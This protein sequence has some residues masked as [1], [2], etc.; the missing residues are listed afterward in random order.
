[1]AIL[2]VLAFYQIT[3]FQFTLKWDV[4]DAV[5]PWKYLIAD[6]LQNHILPLWNPYQHG[7]YPIHADPQSTAWY[8]ITWFI[9]YFFHYSIYTLMVEWLLHIVIAAWGMYRLGITLKFSPL[10]A[11]IMGLSYS[12]SGFFVGNAQ[13][14]NW[15]IAAAWIPFLIHAYLLMWQNRKWKSAFGFS[16][17]AFML[18]SGAYPAF[19]MI[20]LYLLLILFIYFVIT[21]YRN[22][23]KAALFHFV[24]LNLL[25]FVF[26][27]LNG[28]VVLVSVFQLMPFLQRSGGIALRDALFG[29]FSFT[30]WKSFILPFTTVNHDMSAF[31]TDISMTNGYFGLILFAFLMVAFFQKKNFLMWIFLLFGLLNLLVS[32]GDSLPLRTFFYHYIPF[33]NLFRF[34]ALLRIFS[35]FTFIIIGADALNQYLANPN[36]TLLKWIFGL[37]LAILLTVGLVSSSFQI[38]NLYNSTQWKSLFHYSMESDILQQLYFQL[39]IQII[40][41]GLFFLILR[42]KQDTKWKSAALLLLVFVDLGLATQL[43][44]PYTVYDEHRNPRDTYSEMR[45]LPIGFPLQNDKIL[46]HQTD[47]MTPHFGCIWRNVNTF[48]KQIAPDGYN[49][50]MLK[51]YVFLQDSLPWLL[52]NSNRHTVAFFADNISLVKD[53]KGMNLQDSNMIFVIGNKSIDKLSISPLTTEDQLENTLFIPNEIRFKTQTSVDRLLVLQQN[54]YMGWQIEIDTKKT[55]LINVNQSFMGVIVPSGTHLVK[56]IYKPVWVIIAFVVSIISLMFTVIFVLWSN[57]NSRRL[58]RETRPIGR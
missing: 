6:S 26:T 36:P 54:Y 30:S 17:Y 44:A 7:G 27:L 56:F 31:N 42:L 5:F 11:M 46:L 4:L 14:I 57:V 23:N 19:G 51:D 2:V 25:A 9:G 8:P 10:V 29:P 33:F 15:L 37:L 43:N 55:D 12:M 50:L 1:M 58:P 22:E 18:I 40:A 3:F 49:P 20:L 39:F 41:L 52:R 47:E 38:P 21:I 45:Q 32:L 28:A 16:L 35:I 13:H 53:L 34:P 48:R 24:R